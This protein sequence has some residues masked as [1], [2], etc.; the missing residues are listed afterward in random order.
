MSFP[1]I[2][3]SLPPYP[4]ACPPLPDWEIISKPGVY[5]FV[6]PLPLLAPY[7]NQWGKDVYQQNVPFDHLVSE[8]AALST[9]G[10]AV[11]L[12]P[13]GF[14]GVD[15]GG[16]LRFCH[17]G[18]TLTVTL[19][20]G[21]TLY[22][23][24]EGLGYEG[25]WHFNEALGLHA[26]PN[27][28]SSFPNFFTQPEYNTWVEQVRRD[29]NTQ[30]G[31]ILNETLVRDFMDKIE[32]WGLPKGKLVIDFGWH[33]GRGPTMAD[34]IPD[35]KRFPDMLALT[36]EIS[37]RGFTPGL[38]LAPAQIG[39]ASAFGQKNPGAHRPWQAP[40][41]QLFWGDTL[42][43]PGESFRQFMH[44]T[45]SRAIDWG[46]RK[47]KLDLFYGPRE[48]M[49]QCLS[50]AADAIHQ[51]DPSV[52]VEGHVPDAS[53]SAHCQV[54]RTNDVNVNEKMDWKGV[55]LAHF[56]ICEW[57]S[58]HRLINYD[59]IGGNDPGLSPEKFMAHGE[60]F[61]SK[62]AAGYACIGNLPEGLTAEERRAFMSLILDLHP[63]D[64]NVNK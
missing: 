46:F 3:F 62:S 6:M 48:Q 40:A 10:S 7:Y 38:W 42:A 22:H 23:S 25:W 56:R 32:G 61:R 13:R 59:F 34:W 55:T 35:T 14:V 9:S 26:P 4:K 50:Q 31:N 27:P 54:V 37:F 39:T 43:I 11:L 15:G 44:E 8:I 60:L 51:I 63:V 49:I 52:E 17:D 24:S 16:P 19:P 45:F 5:R 36:R 30:D 18:Q 2:L 12:G 20:P 41:E 58:P 33:V 64:K 53:V 28:A 47:F 21:A 29:H 1:S 57:S